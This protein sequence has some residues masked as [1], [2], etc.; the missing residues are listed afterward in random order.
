MFEPFKKKVG[1]VFR[2]ALAATQPGDVAIV[3]AGSLNAG[4]DVEPTFFS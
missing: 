1:P 4:A 2:T 3:G